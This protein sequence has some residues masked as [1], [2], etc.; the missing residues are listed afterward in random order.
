M[1]MQLMH[2]PC[3]CALK[4]GIQQPVHSAPSVFL[5]NNA[6]V[7]N[8]S[9]AQSKAQIPREFSDNCWLFHMLHVSCYGARLVE[10]RKKDIKK[11][12]NNS[13]FRPFQ[14]TV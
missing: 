1:H 3:M 9:Y 13:D 14:D 2:H 8:P 5:T 7:V 11:N 12:M 4:N 10:E 6:Q